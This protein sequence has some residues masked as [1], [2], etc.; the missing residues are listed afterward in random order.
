[1]TKYKV[2]SLRSLR[3]EMKAVARGERPPPA[4]AAKPS[5]NSPSVAVKKIPAVTLP[6]EI[7]RENRIREF[8]EAE[9]DLAKALNYRGRPKKTAR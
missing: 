5:F 2:Q 4:D 7:Y 9:A 1:M 3:E 6:V 8:D